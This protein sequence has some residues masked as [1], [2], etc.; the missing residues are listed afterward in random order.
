MKKMTKKP[1]RKS[2]DSRIKEL[3]SHKKNEQ[4]GKTRTTCLPLLKA[5]GIW[6]YI[7]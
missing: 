2:D 3:E 5:L 4:R 7:R 6:P 1:S